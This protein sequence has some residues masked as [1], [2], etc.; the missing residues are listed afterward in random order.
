MVFVNHYGCYDFASP[1]GGVKE[2]GWGKEMARQSLEE[3]TRLKSIWH[4]FS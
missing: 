2:S 4:R 3:Y 1:F